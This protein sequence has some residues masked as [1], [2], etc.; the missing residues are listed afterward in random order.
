MTRVYKS[1]LYPV[2]IAGI[3]EKACYFIW[4]SVLVSVLAA[5]QWWVFPLGI[6]LHTIC[7]AFTKSDIHFFDVAMKAIR[8][9]NYFVC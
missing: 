6:V 2:V 1:L 4:F 5:G 9:P 3:H 7:I 8:Y